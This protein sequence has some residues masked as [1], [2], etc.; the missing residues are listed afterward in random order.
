MIIGVANSKEARVRLTVIGRHGH[1][2]PITA[3]VDTGY[4]ASLTLPSD[5]IAA[6][7]LRWRSVDRATLADGSE[8]LF[9][10]YEAKVLWDGNVRQVLV[11]EADTDPLL[12]MRMLR[13]HELKLQVRPR[14]KLTIKKL[15]S[16]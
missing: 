4:T 11:D 16:V 7:G 13:G 8:V 3:V 9:D 15:R 6:L 12:G 2:Q 5:L 10:V 1:K 14:G